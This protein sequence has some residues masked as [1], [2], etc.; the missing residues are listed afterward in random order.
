ME[1]L[2]KDLDTVFNLI[3]SIPVS[4]ESVDV[5]AAARNKLRGLYARIKELEKEADSDG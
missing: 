1:K 2:L 4:G 3:S 5:M